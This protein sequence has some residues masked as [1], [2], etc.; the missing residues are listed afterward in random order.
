MRFALFLMLLLLPLQSLALSLTGK[1]VWSGS[2]KI[3]ETIRV[4]RG[5]ELIIE[6]GA[7]ISFLEG[8]LEVAGRLFADGASFSGQNWQ[9]IILKGC[10][11]STIVRN[12]SVT[13]ARIGVQVVGGEPL[14]EQNRFIDNRVGV[15]LRQKSAAT[16]RG[17]RFEQNQKVG[18]FVKDGATAV[19]TDNRFKRH[20]HYAAYIYRATPQRFSG[21]IF[22]QNAIGLIVSFAG[23]DPFLLQ[24]RFAGNKTGVRVERA[25]RPSLVG[26]TITGNEIGVDLFRRADPEIRGNLITH[27]G[28]GI[29]IAYSSYPLITQNNFQDNVSALS[30]EYQS[31]TWEGEQG[32]VERNSETAR[33]SAFGGQNKAVTEAA[34][35]RYIDGT[36]HAPD[37]WWGVKGTTELVQIGPDGNPKFLVDGR[38][39]P[40]FV[41]AGKTYPLD[42]VNF[43]PWSSQPF[44]LLEGL[45]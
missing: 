37:N 17:N 21:N 25:A 3:T 31:A 35:P 28:K 38:D 19:I 16:V 2:V 7:Q 36:I 26:N 4:E 39:L 1:T 11:A 42:L 22:E 6:P 43:V 13:G 12:I 33:R 29:A 18:L 15:E 34:P 20:D 41:D 44:S 10:D 9:G 14:L 24:N 45:E 32:G 40:T 23:S 5:A 30:L 8:S 27:N